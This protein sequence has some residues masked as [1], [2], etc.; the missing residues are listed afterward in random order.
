MEIP[1]QVVLLYVMFMASPWV[2]TS[3][4]PLAEAIALCNRLV[5]ALERGH[6]RIE[7]EGDSKLIIDAVNKVIHP[8]W[9]LIKIVQD[10]QDIATRFNSISFRHIFREANFVA[11]AL[12]NLGHKC[13]SGNMWTNR[14]RSL[15][16]LKSL[17]V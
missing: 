12:A 2:G 10:I 1:L 17:N 13:T 6:N 7:V 4:A 15:W 11:D 5:C 14:V 3:T 8:P 16:R 9:R